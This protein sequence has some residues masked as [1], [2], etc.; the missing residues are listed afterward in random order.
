MKRKKRSKE[1]LLNRIIL[2]QLLLLL[3]LSLAIQIK[4]GSQSNK[5]I[6]L[7]SQGGDSTATE[8]L[9]QNKT[10][11]QETDS[12]QEIDEGNKTNSNQ[13]A[14]ASNDAD[15]NQGIGEG[16]N[17]NSSDGNSV[18]KDTNSSGGISVDNGISSSDGNGVD[19]G[20]SSSDGIS[21]DHGTN[22][23][24]GINAD[25]D[26]SSNQVSSEGNNTTTSNDASSNP[27]VS[28]GNSGNSSQGLNGNNSNVS[29]DVQSVPA[30][31][32]GMSQDFLASLSN[33]QEETLL[34]TGGSRE[35]IYYAQTDSR[36]AQEYYGAKD[37][38]EQYGCGPTALS[39][40]VSNLTK[41]KLDPV[42]MSEWA[43]EN[44]YWFEK[45]GST[46]NLIPEGAKAFG[47]QVQGVENTYEANEKLRTALERGSMVIA[48]MG[49]GSFTRSGH[50]IVFYGI[51]EDGL[52]DVADP[53]SEE[54]TKKTWEL[55]QL[56]REA[57]S[58]AAAEGPF[59]II[60]P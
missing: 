24:A 45:S 29:I 16:N 9:N 41:Y 48:L 21:V 1:Y 38:I 51:N 42:Q 20:T 7:A 34:L 18:D 35:L 54:N 3:I 14:M 33:P 58:W 5:E 22:S 19:N 32:Q 6:V 17:T 40:V 8:A 53:A 13:G 11:G 4:Q 30:F 43:Y 15:S 10:P 55:E 36:W 47:L 50:F 56:V 12:S 39:I 60:E 46:H 37:T 23:N 49:K 26:T 27:G 25:N 31:A 28:E 59:W 57:K 52:V 44:G 2:G